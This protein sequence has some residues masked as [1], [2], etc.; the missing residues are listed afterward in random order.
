MI[1]STDKEIILLKSIPQDSNWQRLPADWPSTL[2]LL[3]TPVAAVALSVYY[4]WTQPFNWKIWVLALA[5]YALTA[6]SITAGYHR[7]FAHRTYDASTPLRWFLALFGAA[8]FQNSI[9]KWATDHRLHHRFVDTDK[10][11]YS[12]N[13]GFLFAHIGWMLQEQRHPANVAAYQR[14][15]LKDPVVRFQHKHYVLLATLM[16]FGLPTL[17]GWGLGSALGGFVI[18]GLLRV[19]LVHHATF[20]INSWCHF[21]GRR[22]FQD[23]H[24]ARDSWLMALVTFGEGYH[25]F[26]HSFASDYRNGVRW[27]HW[28][29]TKWSIQAFARVGLAKN[30]KT[31]PDFEVLQARLAMQQKYLKEKWSHKWEHAFEEQLNSL[32]IK[33]SQ[34]QDRW[35]KLKEEYR[36][37]KDTYAQ[38]SQAKLAALKAEIKMARLEFKMSWA[39]WKAYHSFLLTAAKS[40]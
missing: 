10:D 37:L 31:T 33:V 11:P 18:A 25:N 28:D 26:H 38:T 20:F 35:I 36:S 34:A 16:C 13:K 21:F 5:F 9:L 29:P 23:T 17:I 19:V 6:S 30:L 3:I 14:D 2:F 27:Y 8:A 24:T 39:Q 1:S 15:L 12:I 7:L 40:Y 32:K 4:L 22:T